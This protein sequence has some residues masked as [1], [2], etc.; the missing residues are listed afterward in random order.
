MPRKT[1]QIPAL[2]QALSPFTAQRVID[3][4]VRLHGKKH[5]RTY[6][7]QIVHKYIRAH[8]VAGKIERINPER[9]VRE[10][11]WVNKR[12]KIEV[13]LPRVAD[14][15]QP[16]TPMDLTDYNQQSDYWKDKSRNARP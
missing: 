16:W 3:E 6:L 10:Y 13:M 5:P 9:P 1:L 4:L 8:V 2:M 12:P 11:Q 15:P 14:A 7:V